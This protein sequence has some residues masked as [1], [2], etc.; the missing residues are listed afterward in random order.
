VHFSYSFNSFNP[1]KGGMPQ[2]FGGQFKYIADKARNILAKRSN[3]EIQFGLKAIN[4]MY[5]HA[6][7]AY[8]EAMIIE[9]G[10]EDITVYIAPTVVLAHQIDKFDITE[11]VDF[12]K[13][14][15]EEYFAILALALIGNAVNYE[16]ME[17]P[18]L[19]LKK[20]EIE[21]IK[22]ESIG[23]ALADAM[24]A[25][26]YAESII[27]KKEFIRENSK[28]IK[29]VVNTQICLRNKYAAIVRHTPKNIIK[30]RFVDFYKNGQFKVFALAVKEFY[31]ELTEGERKEICD[32]TKEPDEQINN[33]SRMLKRYMKTETPQLLNLNASNQL[34]S[35]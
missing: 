19:R 1:I 34:K 10:K 22:Q 18:Y 14:Q 8:L 17:Y 23:D 25:V 32:T 27:S 9:L 28:I 31:E 15:W 5:S 21:K 6:E 26:C 4:W 11:Q 3:R 20:T 13:A 24:E 35:V 7:L 16:K 30:R 12:P 33:L 2:L 29:E